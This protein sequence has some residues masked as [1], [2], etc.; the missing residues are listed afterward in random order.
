MHRMFIL[1]IALLGLTAAQAQTSALTNGQ[2][3]SSGTAATSDP[4]SVATSS[5]TGGVTNGSPSVG[6]TSAAIG[7]ATRATSSIAAS[8][9]NSSQSPLQ[10]PGEG[11]DTSTAA[12]NT[13]A[14]A[15]S[16]PSSICPPPV[17]TTDGGSA[18]IEQ[19]AGGITLNGC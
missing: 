13:T 10:L 19:L 16:A 1:A 2:A 15:P 11:S 5:G 9:S 3:N 6:S 7:T 17:P 18:N 8:T 4:L 12:A 14:T